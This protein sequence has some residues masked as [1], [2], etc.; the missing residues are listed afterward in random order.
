MSFYSA[1]GNF[2]QN[3]EEFS[4]SD[5]GS[6]CSINLTPLKTEIKELQKATKE[7]NNNILMKEFTDALVKFQNR[8]DKETSNNK[9]CDMIA[10]ELSNF[11]DINVW[12]I[13]G[14]TNLMAKI[15]EMSKMK[16]M[17]DIKKSIN[18]IKADGYYSN[19]L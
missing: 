1:Q 16:N 18:E 11:I 13:I 12:N 7:F 2:V 9:K 4:Q 6:N 3:I 10:K 8:L 14:M 17:D 5:D 15:N 19:F